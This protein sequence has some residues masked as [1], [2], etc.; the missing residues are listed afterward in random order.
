MVRV[1]SA[2]FVAVVQICIALLA[3][4][5]RAAAAAA[6]STTDAVAWRNRS[7]HRL[8]D[9]PRMYT[10]TVDRV[11]RPEAAVPIP[12]G[13]QFKLVLDIQQDEQGYGWDFAAP[14]DPTIAT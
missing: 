7:H 6:T 12:R 13:R 1:A 8:Q 11:F 9:A 14:T 10:Y 3:N 2:V 5:T 4:S